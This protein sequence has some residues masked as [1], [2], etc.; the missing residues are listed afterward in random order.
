VSV[1][2]A[3]SLLDGVPQPDPPK[4]C[5]ELA[6]IACLTW[7]DSMRRLLQKLLL[8]D[9]TVWGNKSVAY[10]LSLDEIWHLGLI[11]RCRRLH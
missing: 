9:F 6:S 5:E 3:R 8:L 1:E 11:E 4:Y 2:F 7:C 10:N